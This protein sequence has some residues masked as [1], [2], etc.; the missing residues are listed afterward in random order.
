LPR[1]RSAWRAGGP[2]TPIPTVV[3]IGE[4][5]VRLTPQDGET[6]E[7][8]PQLAV[9]VGGA[10]SNVCAAL[11]H[12]GIPTAWISRLPDNALGRRIAAAVRGYGVNVEGVVWA[13]DGFA[14]VFLVQPGAGPR[15]GDVLYYRRDSAFAKIDPDAVDWDLLNRARVVHLTG[16]TPALGTNASRLVSRA[17]VEARRRKVQVSFDVNYRAKLW[18]PSAARKGIEPLLRGLDIVILNDRDAFTVF[19]ERGD[20]ENVARALRSRF[21]CAVLVLTC[22]GVGALAADGA[23][24][25]R[26]Q[27]YPTEIVER[28]GRGDAFAA[29]FLHGYLARGTAHGLRYGAAMAALKQT[30]RGDVCLATPEAVEAVLRGQSGA[31]HR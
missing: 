25:H 31:F 2:G 27:A 29:G 5:L 12:L 20:P 17:I 4:T 26:Q 7:T 22:G 21:R 10:E 9:H 3:G 30:Y 18:G 8:A 16:I 19:G 1:S 14:S 6:L 23:G 15:A 13:P 24:T 11:A 28:I